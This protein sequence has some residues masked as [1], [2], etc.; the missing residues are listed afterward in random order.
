MVSDRVLHAHRIG[1][2]TG[3]EVH[4]VFRVVAEEAEIVQMAENVAVTLPK[5]ELVVSKGR[6]QN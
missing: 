1:V 5:G 2:H 4:R 6:G 3:H